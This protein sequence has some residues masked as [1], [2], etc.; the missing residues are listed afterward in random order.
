M[1]VDENRQASSLRIVDFGFAKQQR[2][3]NGLLMTPCFT[4]EYA[5]PEVLSRKKYDES[6][7]ICRCLQLLFTIVSQMKENDDNC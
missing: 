3:E 7:D 4:K 5:A 6:C 2:A 1:Y